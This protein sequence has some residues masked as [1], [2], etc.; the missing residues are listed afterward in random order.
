MIGPVSSSP[1]KQILK[2]LF[3]Q[4]RDTKLLMLITLKQEFTLSKENRQLEHRMLKKLLAQ[5]KLKI[6]RNVKIENILR[7]ALWDPTD[8]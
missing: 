1:P 6:D 7:V 4:P 3:T 2:A 8:L 5:N